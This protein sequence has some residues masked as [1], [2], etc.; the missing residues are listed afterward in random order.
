MR[1]G[2]ETRRLIE[3]GAFVSTGDGIG[4]RR[5]LEVHHARNAQQTVNPIEVQRK[6]NIPKAKKR[7]KQ[8]AKNAERGYGLEHRLQHGAAWLRDGLVHQHDPSPIACMWCTRKTNKES[9][10]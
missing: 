2:R 10:G 6:R 8:T 9:E 7:G 4:H 1:L 5:E 3:G